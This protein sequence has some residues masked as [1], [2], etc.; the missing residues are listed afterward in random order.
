[1]TKR[2]GFRSRTQEQIWRSRLIFVGGFGG[3][4]YELFIDKLERPSLL[5]LLGGMMGLPA[6]FKEQDEGDDDDDTS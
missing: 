1:M 2:R 6:F 3:F 5:I 4:L